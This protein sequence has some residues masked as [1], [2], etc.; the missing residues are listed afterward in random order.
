MQKVLT[1]LLLAIL[2][3]GAGIDHS[4]AAFPVKETMTLAGIRPVK[5]PFSE[6]KTGR[7]VSQVGHI[8]HQRP[9][10]HAES[11]QKQGWPGIVSLISSLFSL[12]CLFTMVSP[13]FLPFAIIAIVLGAIGTNNRRYYNNGLALAGLIIGI[14]EI[15][16][17]LALI[18]LFISA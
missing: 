16:V 10:S 14:V 7:L 5:K 11:K 13:L 17:V 6:T 4:Y 3:F 12:A 18:A 1:T 8:A 15:V 2:L 9:Y